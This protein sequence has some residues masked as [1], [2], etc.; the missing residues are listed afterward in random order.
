MTED[1][2]GVLFSDEFAISYV[3]KHDLIEIADIPWFCGDFINENR[4]EDH[5][6]GIIHELY[7]RGAL[8]LFAPKIVTV[9]LS[10]Y[11]SP[12]RQTLN[13][14]LMQ[15]ENIL[16]SD[17]GDHF[18]DIYK[19]IQN[20]FTDIRSE[21]F[22]IGWASRENGDALTAY[23]ITF[24]TVVSDKFSTDDFLDANYGLMEG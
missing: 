7:E 5:I 15:T 18:M 12:H 8:Y 19:G 10:K 4:G 16:V 11:F 20:T 6:N 3:N 13:D 2:V 21:L 24:T 22:F 1:I 14:F 9:S 23:F 17:D